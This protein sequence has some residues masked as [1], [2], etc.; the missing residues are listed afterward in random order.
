MSILFWVLLA[1]GLAVIEMLS[2]TFFP[3]FFSVSAVLAL[4]VYLLDGA[5]WLQWL[6]FGVGGLLFSA[7][8]RPIA[9]RQLQTGPVLKNPVEEMAGRRGVVETPVDG[10]AGT[11]TVRL[12]GQVWTA[13]PAEEFAQ[14]DAGSDV[15]IKEVRGA[16]L[17]VSPLN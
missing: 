14:I 13:V 10:R 9:R 12:S 11:G 7:A 4:I 6:V 1:V 8:L 5:D 16:T 17:V 3:I 15:E 2:I